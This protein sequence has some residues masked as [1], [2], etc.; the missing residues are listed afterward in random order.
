MRWWLAAAA[1]ASGAAIAG[2]LPRPSD[3]GAQA[4]DAVIRGDYMA[5]RQV[6][7]K[8]IASAGPHG[9]DTYSLQM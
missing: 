7:E 2:D 5:A 3:P 6:L 1:M 8:A 9:P 4:R